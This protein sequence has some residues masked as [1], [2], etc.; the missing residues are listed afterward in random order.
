[1]YSL[2]S[3]LHGIFIS[4]WHFVWH[5]TLE[6][7]M[8]KIEISSLKQRSYVYYLVYLI[9]CIFY[10]FLSDF[11][12][13]RNLVWM[14]FEN[15]RVL[16]GLECAGL[17]TCRAASYS[18]VTI[19]GLRWRGLCCW[20]HNQLSQEAALRKI[21]ATLHPHCYWWVLLHTSIICAR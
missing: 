21:A 17:Q 20:K 12:F 1:M 2:L 8:C 13:P 14:Y 16:M 7:Y 3:I 9:S 19:R 4:K 15:R 18:L 6:Q 11:V 10:K 5:F